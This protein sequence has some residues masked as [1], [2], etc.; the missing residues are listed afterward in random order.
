MTS[1]DEEFKSLIEQRKELAKRFANW[2][3]IE[4]LPPIPKKAVL[5]YINGE[6]IGLSGGANMAGLDKIGFMRLLKRLD[7][8]MNG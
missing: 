3:A 8:P 4:K 6:V 7:V 5:G 1:W 2:D